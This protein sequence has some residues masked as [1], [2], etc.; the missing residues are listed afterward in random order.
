[1]MAIRLYLTSALSFINYVFIGYNDLL[2]M[3]MIL[4]HLLSQQ[5]C[6]LQVIVCH[7][8]NEMYYIDFC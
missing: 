1:M 3:D 6:N 8:G 5:N 7:C 2:I 4:V